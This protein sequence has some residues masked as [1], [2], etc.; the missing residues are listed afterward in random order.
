M[1]IS[2]P[3]GENSVVVELPHGWSETI[4]LWLSLVSLL[5]IVLLAMSDKSQ[6]GESAVPV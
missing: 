2:L 5:L 4:G 6:A 3:A 1:E